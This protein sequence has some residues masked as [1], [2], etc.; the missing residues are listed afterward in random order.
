VGD[1]QEQ[2]A[3][4]YITMDGF[5]VSQIKIETLIGQPNISLL[6]GAYGLHL[7]CPLVVFID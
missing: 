1:R 7:K 3:R 5:F 4:P 6:T 2:K